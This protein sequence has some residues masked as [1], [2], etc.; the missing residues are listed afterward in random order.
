MINLR[1]V[2][3]TALAGSLAAVTANAGE[4]SV[5]GAANLTYTTGSGLKTRNTVISVSYFNMDSQEIDFEVVEDTNLISKIGSSIKQVKAFA[6][7][8]RGQAARLGRAI[9]FGEANETEVCSLTDHE[10]SYRT[11]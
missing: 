5:S 6:C 1:K 10:S 7:T 3:L 2:G 9:L 8:S 11:T 4:L